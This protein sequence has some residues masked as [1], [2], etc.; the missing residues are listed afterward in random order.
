MKFSKVIKYHGQPTL[1]NA[2]ND[3]SIDFL[4]ELLLGLCTSFGIADSTYSQDEPRTTIAPGS[5]KGFISVPNI[6]GDT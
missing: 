1:V 4:E 6:N 2:A 3:P 5:I